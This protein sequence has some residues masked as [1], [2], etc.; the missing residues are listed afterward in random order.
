MVDKG[1]LWRISF[2]LLVLLASLV[3]WVRRPVP[4]PQP[5]HWGV[6][7]AVALP[8][9]PVDV[10]RDHRIV[11]AKAPATAAPSFKANANANV[12]ATAKPA[13]KS[14]AI[15]RISWRPAPKAVHPKACRKPV[16]GCK[17]A[18]AAAHPRAPGPPAGVQMA[19]LASRRAH[20]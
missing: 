3:T 19:A 7:R 4:E 16:H 6:V 2:G 15:E 11:V 18:R 13:M 5:V 8:S 10:S 20:Q 1:L 14:R 17:V 12:S 9:L